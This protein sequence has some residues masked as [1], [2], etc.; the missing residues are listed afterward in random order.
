MIS[1]G[2]GVAAWSTKEEVLGAIGDEDVA[3]TT[4]PATSNSSGRQFHQI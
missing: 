2:T 4:G 1:D 3:Q